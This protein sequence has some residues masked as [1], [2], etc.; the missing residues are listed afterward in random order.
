[1][2]KGLNKELTTIEPQELIEKAYPDLV[3]TFKQSRK[4]IKRKKATKTIDTIEKMLQNTSISE[5][6]AKKTTKT[7]DSYFKRAVVNNFEK[8]AASSTPV[9]NKEILSMDLSSFDDTKNNAD[10]SD[11]IDEI[12]QQKPD[13]ILKQLF[14]D[15]NH[16]FF[17]TKPM[18]NDIFEE[19]FNELCATNRNSSEEE[20]DEESFVITEVPLIER[21]KHNKLL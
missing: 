5:P 1:M 9:K 7:I 13:F 16:S 3:E 14:Q 18:E 8:E 6:K 10:L 15:N 21:L 2:F 11:I 19:T 20:E 17:I 4:P 12:I